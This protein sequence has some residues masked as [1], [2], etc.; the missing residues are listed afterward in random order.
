LRVI[1]ATINSNCLK[2]PYQF[3]NEEPTGLVNIAYSIY[4]DNLKAP[5]WVYG[6]ITE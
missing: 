6:N 2:R 5:N 4:K 3:I 1:Q